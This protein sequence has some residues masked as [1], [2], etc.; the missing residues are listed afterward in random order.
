MTMAAMSTTVA[1]PR[2]PGQPV[3]ANKSRRTRRIRSFAEYAEFADLPKRRRLASRP[4]LTGHDAMSKPII[5]TINARLDVLERKVLGHVRR[6]VSRAEKARLEGVTP[7]TIARR[8]AAGQIEPPDIIN[9]RW[10]FWV[11]EAAPPERGATM[12]S[13]GNTANTDASVMKT[14]NPQLRK[15]KPAQAASEI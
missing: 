5:A 8:V 11:D 15:R 2:S 10:Y 4:A 3:P 9:G 6:R 12:A 14:R 1:V 13:V 7:R